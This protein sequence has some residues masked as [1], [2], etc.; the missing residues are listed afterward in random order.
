MF[1]KKFLILL[2]LLFSILLLASSVSADEMISYDNVEDDGLIDNQL[3]LEEDSLE[4][5]DSVED[6][7]LAD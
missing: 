7:N 3:T 1:N 6:E 2:T 4:V 5:I